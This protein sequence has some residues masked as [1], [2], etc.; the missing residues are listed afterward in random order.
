MEGEGGGN[1]AIAAASERPQPLLLGLPLARSFIRAVQGDVAETVDDLQAELRLS[2]HE[3]APDFRCNPAFTDRSLKEDGLEDMLTFSHT[4]A[5]GGVV[6]LVPGGRDIKVTNDTKEA[7]LRASLKY[8]LFDAVEEAAGAFRTGVCNLVGAAHLVLLS[9]PELQET[10]SGKADISD[11]DLAAWQAR[12][13]INPAVAKQAAWFFELLR[14]DLRNSRSL[15]LKFATGSDRWPVDPSGFRFA[16]EP[17][18]GGDQTLPQAMTCAN[19]LQ[20]PRF[21][22]P[23]PLAERLVKA[24]SLGVDLQKL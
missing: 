10:W 14:G 11:E 23:A 3:Q 13:D 24:A 18:D 15:V 19:M 6:D 20:L 1:A 22:G 4:T 7:W 5:G 17:V 2:Q 12:T 16:I 9:A 8:E 21:S